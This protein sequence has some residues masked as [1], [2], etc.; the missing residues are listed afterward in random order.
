MELEFDQSWEVLW[1]G[2]DTGF[3]K[4]DSPA[5][6]ARVVVLQDLGS[7][8]LSQGQKEA[9]RAQHRGRQDIERKDIPAPADARR[10]GRAARVHYAK[11]PASDD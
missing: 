10:R 9:F 11:I 4:T 8:I 3:G 6:T 1:G 5:Q 7:V 2:H